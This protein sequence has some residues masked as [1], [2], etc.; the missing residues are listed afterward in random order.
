MATPAKERMA[1]MRKKRKG[2]ALSVWL[3]PD[4]ARIFQKIKTLTGETNDTIAEMAFRAF[5]ENVFLKR[6]NELALAIREHQKAE[7][8]KDELTELYRELV[9]VLCLDYG[10]ADEIKKALNQLD[11]PNYSGNAGTWKVNQIRSLLKP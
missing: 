3:Y 8:P 4:T 1:K 9:T 7:K 2:K 6:I 5:Y 10:T 11:I